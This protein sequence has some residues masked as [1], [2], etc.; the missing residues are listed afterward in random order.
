MDYCLVYY[1][2]YCLVY[3]L[4]YYLLETESCFTEP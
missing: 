2:D 1:L 4:V 3:Y